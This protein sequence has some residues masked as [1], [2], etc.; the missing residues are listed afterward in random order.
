[1]YNHN[2]EGCKTKGRT[3]LR[4]QVIDLVDSSID[5]TSVDSLSDLDTV[6]DRLLI[7]RKLHICF[8]RKLFSSARVA[9]TDEIVHNDKINVPERQSVGLSLMRC[10]V[11]GT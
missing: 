3:Y 9:F 2:K 10:A 11:K 7:N 5:I 8:L 4:V 6:L 1:V